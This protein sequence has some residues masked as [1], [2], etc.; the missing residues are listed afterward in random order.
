MLTVMT[1][2][3]QGL[4]RVAA[5]LLAGAGGG[6]RIMGVRRAGSAPRGWTEQPLD[7]ASLDSVRAFAAALPDRPVERLIL[8]AGGQRPDVAT[9]SSDGF[10]TVFASNHLGH[11]L[12]LRLIERR[13]GPGARVVITT[14]GTHDPAEKTG[15]PPPRHADADLLAHPERDPAR[16]R[17]SA[18][19]GM[20]AYSSSKLCNL[21]TAR[22]LAATD[23]A[24]T[25]GWRVFAY[26]PGLTPGTGLVRAQPWPVRALVWPLLPLVRPFAKGMNS[27]ADAGRGLFELASTTDAPPG[28]V[29][30]SLRKGRLIWPDPSELARDDEA[31]RRLWARSA[32]LV[33]LGA[34]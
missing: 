30:A 32:A 6:E 15:V 34:A 25:Q 14:S 13:L 5:E 20:R 1:G 3:S 29:Y 11:Y 24:Q 10:E 7:L 31:T 16:D 21:M 12:L 9:R 23:Q 4:G 26:D 33:G 22:A 17:L 27:L 28:R 8:N 2:G 18:V 19:A